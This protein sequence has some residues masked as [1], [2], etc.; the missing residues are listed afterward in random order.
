MR[1]TSIILMLAG[2]GLVAAGCDESP[3]GPPGGTAALRLKR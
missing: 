1:G 2:V 3:I